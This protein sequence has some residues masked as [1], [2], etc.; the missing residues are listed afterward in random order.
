MN[1]IQYNK[2]MTVGRLKKLL[3]D[4]SDDI[5]I[6]VKNRN[7]DDT[8]NIFVW[9]EDQP[10]REYVELQGYKPYRDMTKEERELCE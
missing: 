5:H 10:T 9:H 6:N 8:A 2:P 4:I 3:E 1:D 7:G